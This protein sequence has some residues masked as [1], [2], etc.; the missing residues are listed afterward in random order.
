MTKSSVRKPQRPDFCSAQLNSSC[1]HDGEV[2]TSI[3]HNSTAVPFNGTRVLN[4]VLNLVYGVDLRR[5][6]LPL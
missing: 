6:D 5:V 2:A 3:I 1:E 4:L